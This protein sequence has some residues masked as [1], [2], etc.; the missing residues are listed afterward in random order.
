MGGSPDLL[1]GYRRAGEA[2]APQEMERLWG[3]PLPSVAGLAFEEML[4]DGKLKGLLVLGDNPLMLA[5]NRA[6]LA[7]RLQALDF[8]AVIDS[9]GTD[10]ARLAHVVLPDVPVWGKEGTTVSADRRVLRMH[11]ATAAQGEAQPAWRILG[12]L[13]SRLA[14]R[15]QAGEIRLSY[16]GP[17]AIMDEI[18]QVVP[19]YANATYVELDSGAQQPLDGLGPKTAV[20]QEVPLAAA[21][22]EGDGFLL[23][24]GRSL[25]T[26][27]EGAALHSPEADK[28]HREESVEVNPADAA[29]LGVANGD[30]VLLRNDGGELAIRVHLTE[31]VQAG[32]L[33]VP[34]YYEGGAVSALF[35][36]DHGVS[37]VQVARGR[38]A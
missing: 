13:G 6:A 4:S 18:A 33:Y 29:A 28:L 19:L 22:P 24:T 8:L 23:T 5:P 16:P 3:A 37:R 20:P 1:P 31:A 15:L 35:E 7:Q 27:Y 14:Q 38:S 12:E 36:G 30:E 26:S 2:P 17:A 25:Y 34:L 21:A 10:T 11:A 32:T 9:L